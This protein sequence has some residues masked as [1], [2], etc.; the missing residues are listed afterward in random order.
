MQSII[1][2]CLLCV[3]VLQVMLAWT[4]SLQCFESIANYWCNI[5]RLDWTKFHQCIQTITC[6]STFT[7]STHGSFSANGGQCSIPNDICGWEWIHSVRQTTCWY[8][9]VC[10]TTVDGPEEKRATF[11]IITKKKNLFFH[12]VLSIEKKTTDH[13]FFFF[14]STKWILI[15]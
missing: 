15:E 13:F 1:S 10:S 5:N 11:R 2:L 8:S 3:V 6:C 4:R 12:V 14:F 7:C 9:V